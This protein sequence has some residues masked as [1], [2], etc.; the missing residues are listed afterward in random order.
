MDP[1]TI[2]AAL[3]GTQSVAD[4][5]G[6][7]AA[8]VSNWKARGLPAARVAQLRKL[9]VRKGLLNLTLEVL[10]GACAGAEAA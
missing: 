3:G 4:D 6:V 2:I 5:L 10:L 7:T 1:T 8:A 9:A